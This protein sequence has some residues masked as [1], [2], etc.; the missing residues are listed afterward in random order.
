M[1]PIVGSMDT[2]VGSKIK[3]RRTKLK[4]TLQALADEVGVTASFL[5]Q[6]EKGK[7]SPSLATLKKIA[8]ALSTTIA[9]L[10]DT[11]GQKPVS[12]VVRFTE[13]RTMKDPEINIVT[14]FL[15]AAET[16]K[17]MEPMIFTYLSRS[18]PTDQRYKHAGDEFALVLTGEL[19][20]I[21]DDREYVLKQGDSIYFH[22]GFPHVFLNAIDGKTEVLSIN[23]PPSF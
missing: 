8:D 1:S 6:V 15:A 16:W 14:Q 11:N 7:A 18:E 5:S 3:V 22:S 19:K 10:V 12:P 21:L 20:I 9:T 13:R 23:T 17:M 4:L 2:Q